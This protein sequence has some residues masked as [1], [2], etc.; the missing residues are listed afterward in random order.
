MLEFNFITIA[1]ILSN[2][3]YRIKNSTTDNI[4]EVV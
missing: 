2:A 1:R 4:L 3:Y